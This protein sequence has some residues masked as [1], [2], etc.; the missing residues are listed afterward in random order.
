MV[1]YYH[2]YRAVLV[3]GFT[4]TFDDFLEMCK[5][6]V[7]IHGDWFDFNLG[8][9]KH[10]DDPKFLFV[11][12]EEMKKDVRAVILKLCQFL[13]KQL[14]PEL[15]DAIIKHTSFKEMKQNKMVNYEFE[16]KGAINHD[17]SPFMRK[18]IVG[19]WQSHFSAEQNMFY[20]Q[21]LKERLAGTGLAFT[22]EG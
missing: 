12:Y 22:Y 19:D 2:F 3:F 4:G 21:L 10:K 18:G 13:D 17:I 7:L 14:E 15:I 5:N 8:W 11:T 1:S 6:D 16:R 9:W 20:E